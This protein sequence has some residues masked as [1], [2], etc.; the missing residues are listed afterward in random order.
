VT[1]ACWITDAATTG[2]PADENR[3]L[4]AAVDQL[5]NAQARAVPHEVALWRATADAYAARMVLAERVLRA[6]DRRTLTGLQRKHMDAWETEWRR[7]TEG[8]A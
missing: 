3:R 5:V 7:Q 8:A 4:R 1:A 6:L 2:D